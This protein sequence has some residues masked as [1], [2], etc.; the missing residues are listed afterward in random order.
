[1]S[2]NVFETLGGIIKEESLFSLTNK[3]L[4]NTLVLE[5]KEPFPGYHHDLPAES[6]PLSVFLVTRKNYTRE[7]ITRS[8]QQIKK[9]CSFEFDAAASE[10]TIY[11]DTYPCIRLKNLESYD[12]I[13]DLQSFFMNEGVT[14]SKSA[15]IA[16]KAIIKVKKTFILSEES[17]VIFSDR[18]EDYQGYFRIPK[19]I[20]WK[21]FEKVTYSV[22]NNWK[23]KHFD[24]ALGF[25]YH[26][27]EIYDVVRIYH[28][29]DDI[30]ILQQL[31]D[32]YLKELADY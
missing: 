24:A 30:S 19:Q 25:F 20:S 2:A 13:S 3:V 10:I 6:A 23:G 15:D 11:N 1:M 8:A 16:A 14:F 27:F 12:Q 21:L 22:R 29:S 31:R 18:L 17:D 7:E 4:P 26:N 9:Y 28:R 5:S 32:L